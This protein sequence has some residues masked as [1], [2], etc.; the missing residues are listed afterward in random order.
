MGRAGELDASKQAN[1]MQD[2]L[3]D[4][5]GGLNGVAGKDGVVGKGLPKTNN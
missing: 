4:L 3:K 2:R 5:D 1:R